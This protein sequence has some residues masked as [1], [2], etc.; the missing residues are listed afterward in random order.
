MPNKRLLYQAEDQLNAKGLEAE[1]KDLCNQVVACMQPIQPHAGQP[2]N[3]S[4]VVIRLINEEVPES[5][6]NFWN[7]GELVT[8]EEIWNYLFLFVIGYN[9]TSSFSRSLTVFLTSRI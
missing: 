6:E 4:N 5:E 2:S 8:N 3:L 7:S 1:A 9:S